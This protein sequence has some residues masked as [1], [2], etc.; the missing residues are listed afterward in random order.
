MS[1]SAVQ[2]S[3]GQVTHY[4]L[5]LVDMTRELEA[6]ASVD[7]MTYFDRLTDL[8]NRNFLLGRLKHLL[9]ETG[10]TPSALV[11]MDLDHFKRINDLR[12]HD[13]GD[14]LLL[15][16]ARRLHVLLGKEDALSRF[17]GGTFA[18]LVQIP[19]VDADSVE[20][21]IHAYCERVL[22]AM[23]EPF[24]DHEEGSITVT[25]S[26]GWASLLSGQKSPDAVLRDVELAMYGAKGNGRDRVLEFD[27][28]MREE[29]VRME[30]LTN[31]L[32]EAIAE[33]TLELHLQ[34]QTDRAGKVTGAEMLLR[35]TRRCGEV[36]SPA[37]FIPIAEESGLILPIGDWVLQQA[38]ERLVAWSG[39][40]LK[41]E[42]SLAV[43][44]SV[45]QFTQ[46]GF[47]DGVRQILATTGADTSLLKL[48]ITES[49]VLGDLDEAARKLR[50]LRKLGI[51]VSLDD[52]GTGYSSLAY[53]SHL[54]LDQLKIDQSFVNRLENDTADAMVAQ[55]IIGMGHGLN[56]EVIAEGVETPAQHDFLLMQGCDAFQ[57]YLLARP[58]ALS[59]FERL[60]RSSPFLP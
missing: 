20:D 16:V 38:C 51:R 17:S 4:V 19:E 5:S 25:A 43:N 46:P 29:M 44:V 48:E 57:G 47:V 59:Q 55:T 49:V 24:R 10:S 60:L 14:R 23:R 52:F 27:P 35:W 32:R 56:L 18:F 28:S 30:T 21:Y 12:G 8:P 2:D 15:L 9:S 26:I 45:K 6:H 58:M 36:I 53:L 50:Q 33:Q 1:I 37:L 39:D 54:P 13:S 11:L 34:A 3:E 42:L 7:R 40:P 41:S 31:E 22:A